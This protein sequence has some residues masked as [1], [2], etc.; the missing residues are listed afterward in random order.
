LCG[1]RTDID[2]PSNLPLTKGGYKLSAKL[3]RKLFRVKWY[4]IFKGI[5]ASPRYC[6]AVEPFIPTK[7]ACD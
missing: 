3:R 2:I 6:L 5:P 4:F 7:K 1:A